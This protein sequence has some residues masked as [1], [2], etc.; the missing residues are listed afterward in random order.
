MTRN[1][2]TLVPTTRVARLWPGETC[3]ILGGGPSLVQADVDAVRG[4]ARVLAIKE[5]GACSLPGR[6][7]MAPWADVLYACDPKYWKYEQGAPGFAGLKYALAP[8]TT[9]WPGV[10]VL[11]DTGHEGLELQP[12]GLR[13]GHNSGYQAVNLAVHLGCARLVLLGFDMWPGPDGQHNWFGRHPNH[14]VSPYAIFLARFATVAPALT[15]AGVTVLNAS[16]RTVMNAF[17]RVAL[18]DIVW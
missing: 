5:A 4:K 10:Q 15:A 14:V 2:E 13:T 17:P 9:P 8:Q 3:V 11:R 16:R 18:E 12:D 1:R 6:P 7:P